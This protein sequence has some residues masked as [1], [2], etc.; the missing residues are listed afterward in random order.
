MWLLSLVDEPE[1]KATL[2]GFEMRACDYPRCLAELPP[3]AL[4][5][6]DGAW[7]CSEHKVCP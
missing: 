3:G 4:R 6:F 2:E 1:A 7:R 5:R